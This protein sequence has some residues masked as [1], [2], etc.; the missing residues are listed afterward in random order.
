MVAM[1]FHIKTAASHLI[2]NRKPILDLSVFGIHLMQ[3]LHFFSKQNCLQVTKTE[4][5]RLLQ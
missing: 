3:A 1:L 2:G 5:K 4:F